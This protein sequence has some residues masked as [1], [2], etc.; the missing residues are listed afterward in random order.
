MVAPF[1]LKKFF[2]P[3]V[4]KNLFVKTFLFIIILNNTFFQKIVCRT[5][6]VLYICKHN[7]PLNQNNMSFQLKIQQQEL[8]SLKGQLKYCNQALSQSDIEDWEKKEFEVLK[9]QYESKVKEI[10]SLIKLIK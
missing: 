4:F 10:E 6:N 2:N 3:C 9:L 1:F 8:K 7:N 5:K